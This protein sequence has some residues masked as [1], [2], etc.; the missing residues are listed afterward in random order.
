MP[1]VTAKLGSVPTDTMGRCKSAHTIAP[2]AGLMPATYSFSRPVTEPGAS[3]MGSN[4]G[5]AGVIPLR[6][7]G[8]ASLPLDKAYPVAPSGPF[9]VVRLLRFDNGNMTGNPDWVISST[10]YVDNYP[11]H[12]TVN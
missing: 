4:W 1:L 2:Y 9:P 8:L 11:D 3:S 6:H 10:T 12:R 7:A 5:F